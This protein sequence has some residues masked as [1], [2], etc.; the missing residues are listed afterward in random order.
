MH[1]KLILHVSVWQDIKNGEKLSLLYSVTL[2]DF[3]SYLNSHGI[4]YFYDTQMLSSCSQKP[5]IG[6]NPE[7]G[8]GTEY[9]CIL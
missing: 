7:H 8:Q 1:W 4:T 6:P 2:E 5:G 9:I 3:H